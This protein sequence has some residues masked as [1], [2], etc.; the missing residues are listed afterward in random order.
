[1]KCKDVRNFIIRSRRSEPSG[2]RDTAIAEH[3]QIC[4]QCRAIVEENKRLDKLVNDS[5]AWAPT[6]IYWNSL[7][8]RIHLRIDKKK[9][10]VILPWLYRSLAPAAAALLIVVLS[11]SLLRLNDSNRDLLTIGVSSSE[12]VNYLEQETIVNPYAANNTGDADTIGN[13]DATVLRDLLMDENSVASYY[14]D[15][16]G[17]ILETVNNDEAEKLFA[18]LYDDVKNNK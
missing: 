11:L 6:D 7:L 18:L 5:P 2:I 8:P 1:M 12:I 3:M 9:E 15:K 14:E 13:D 4:P 16:A 10:P 17:S